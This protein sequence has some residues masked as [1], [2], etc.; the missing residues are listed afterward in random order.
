MERST[1]DRAPVQLTNTPLSASVTA[2]Y[3]SSQ[4]Q[5][6][7]GG[8]GLWKYVK[9]EGWSDEA[10]TLTLEVSDDRSSWSQLG[11]S[12][13]FTADVINKFDWIGLTK[14]Y[15]RWKF[16][17]GGTD[18]TVFKLVEDKV[19]TP[20]E[21]MATSLITMQSAATGTGNGTALTVTGFGSSM[22]QITGTFVGT[23]TFEVT[24]DGTNYEGIYGVNSETGVPV[25]TATAPGVFFF[26]HPAG[27]A[28]RAR[29]SAYTSGSITAKGRA[30]G[31]S[32]P[33]GN[34]QV[35]GSSLKFTPQTA[36][37]SG[38]GNS[39]TLTVAASKE[40]EIYAVRA[41]LTSTAIV[42]NRRLRL[43][44]DDGTNEV[45]RSSAGATQAAS[46]TAAYMFAP[47]V[48]RETS[49]TDGQYAAPMPV[50][51][52]KAGYRVRV[53]DSANIDVTDTVS[54]VFFYGERTV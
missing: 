35:M 53:L 7:L 46:S 34:V 22:I 18:Q 4:G 36:V 31:V 14:R 38:V 43:A 10:G 50:L 44:I 33:S 51:V 12:L 2:Y 27:Q 32:I 28:V 39:K 20:L 1:I 48:T 26:S 37:D 54:V 47:H 6:R 41:V 29:V 23:V 11:P 17:N 21:A 15:W 9:A 45:Y 52:L 5:D 19:V 3:P 49:L 40:Y 24:G 25:L 16:V 13:T 8:T 30:L 42:G